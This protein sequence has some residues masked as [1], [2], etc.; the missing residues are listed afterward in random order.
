MEASISGDL[1]SA[2]IL[3]EAGASVNLEERTGE[4][5]LH[6]AARCGYG[7][8]LVLLIEKEADVNRPGRLKETPMMAAASEGE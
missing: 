4:T 6:F 3:I 8:C 1:E 5:A 2:K 7:H